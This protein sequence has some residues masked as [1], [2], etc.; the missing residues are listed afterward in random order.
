MLVNI[1]SIAYMKKK[2]ILIWS[3]KFFPEIF[4]V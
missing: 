4:S 2:C 1:L 3:K